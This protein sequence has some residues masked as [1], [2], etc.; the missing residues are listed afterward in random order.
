M[1]WP[2]P[3]NFCIVFAQ[4]VILLHNSTRERKENLFLYKLL[5]TFLQL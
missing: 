4:N 3:D 1:K 2:P 5:I